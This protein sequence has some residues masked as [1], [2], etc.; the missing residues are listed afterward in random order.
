[1]KILVATKETQGRRTND[2]CWCKEGELLMFSTFQCSGG[3]VDDECGC[4]RAMSGIETLTATTTMRVVEEDVA[5]EDLIKRIFDALRQG[6][7]DKM[8][9]DVTLL[10]KARTIVKEIIEITEEF[11][12]G[13]VLERREGFQVRVLEVVR[14][15]Q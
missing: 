3:F 13:V 10:K 12:P 7:W 2:F 14:C 9:N 5:V 4:H 6:S 8:F 11:P 15:M 1:M